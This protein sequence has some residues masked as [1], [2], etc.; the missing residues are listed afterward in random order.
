LVDYK[1]KTI[2]DSL[3][4]INGITFNTVDSLY[5]FKTGIGYHGSLYDD[6]YAF[7]VSFPLERI[8]TEFN[9]IVVD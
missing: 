9:K 7:G 4:K 1:Y 8:R 2:H 5:E 3:E 6:K